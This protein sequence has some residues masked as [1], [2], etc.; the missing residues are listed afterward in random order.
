MNDGI[1]KMTGPGGAGESLTGNTAGNT[2]LQA[3]FS[4][5]R[6]QDRQQNKNSF[7]GTMWR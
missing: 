7:V 4:R 6:C 2:P 3:A 1:N 5:H